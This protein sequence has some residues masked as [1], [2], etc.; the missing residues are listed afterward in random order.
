MITGI[1]K[2][3]GEKLGAMELQLA[4]N[5]VRDDV[6]VLNVHT[7]IADKETTI[8]VPRYIPSSGWIP[9]FG[10]P[11]YNE[12]IGAPQLRE[13]EKKFQSSETNYSERFRARRKGIQ[14]V[15]ISLKRRMKSLEENYRIRELPLTSGNNLGMIEVDHSDGRLK[16]TVER[17]IRQ[18]RKPIN[19]ISTRLDRQENEY[20]KTVKREEAMPDQLILK[21]IRMNGVSPPILRKL[22]PFWNKKKFRDEV[23]RVLEIGYLDY[24]ENESR[25][26]SSRGRWYKLFNFENFDQ[27][28]LEVKEGNWKST[29]IEFEGE[30]RSVLKNY[31][32]YLYRY[33]G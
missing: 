11:P 28:F 19:Q 8:E 12:F 33:G 3:S 24:G 9:I 17:E 13:M 31:E 7:E 5:A 27:E 1:D 25:L 30:R 10:L 29:E 14:G 18:E 23:V 4:E 26:D 6:I 16:M 2:S 20:F 32:R 21:K 22:F 15:E